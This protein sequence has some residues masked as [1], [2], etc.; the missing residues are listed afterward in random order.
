MESKTSKYP[1]Y[2]TGVR[3]KIFQAAVLSL[4]L[5]LAAVSV[6]GCLL[7][8]LATEF[9]DAPQW[10][11]MMFTTFPTVGGMVANIIGGASAAKIGKKNL[12][13]IGIAMAFLGGFL[14]MFMPTLAL[15]IAVRVIAGLGVGLIQPLSASLIIDCFEGDTANVMMG[16]QSAC[17]G[18]GASL[19]SYTMAAIMVYDW[20]YA[21]F[22]YLYAVAIFLLVLFGIPAFVNDIGREKKTDAVQNTK[23]QDTVKK[24]LPIAAYIGCA[25]QFIYGLG[26]GALDNCLSLASTET[27]TITTVQAAAIASWGGIAAL[28]GGLIFGVVVKFTGMKAMGILSLALNIIGLAIVGVT[29]TTM[30]WYVGVTILKVGFCWWMP[31]VNFLVNDGTDETNSALATSLGFVG[32]SLGAFIFG[33]VFTFIGNMFGGLTYHQAFTYG[34]VMVVIVLVLV[35]GYTILHKDK[36]TA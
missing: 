5:L 25:A 22:A 10:Y 17:V 9:P 1:N 29:D 35:G 13:L 27:G 21:Y 36:K 16:F 30:M 26:Y 15:K 33:Y 18:L 7:G 34:A 14:P 28:I 2:P 3:Y 12:C 19:F 11:L 8:D 20:H 31:Y 4:S 23:A 32:N 6:A 24:A